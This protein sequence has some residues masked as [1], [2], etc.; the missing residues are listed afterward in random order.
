[1]KDG[2][3]RG[4]MKGKRGRRMKERRGEDEEEV[5]G[6]RRGEEGVGE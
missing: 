1:M 2:E 3:Q 5:Q 4:A 6:G